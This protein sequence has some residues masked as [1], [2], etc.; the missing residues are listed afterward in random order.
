M[1]LS[2]VRDQI[3]TALEGATSGGGS[4]LTLTAARIVLGRDVQAEDNTVFSGLEAA[5]PYCLVMPGAK[6]GEVNDATNEYEIPLRL[7]IGIPKGT[8]NTFELIEDL[9]EDMEDQLSP[10]VLT[11]DRPEITIHESTAVVAYEM[12]VS[13]MGC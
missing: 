7:Y 11:W 3:K 12:T 2:T 13:A 4:P 9:I 10:H 8:D 6:R 1:G 5:G